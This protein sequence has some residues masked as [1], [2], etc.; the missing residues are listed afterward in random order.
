MLL[1]LLADLM[2][3]GRIQLEYEFAYHYETVAYWYGIPAASL[4]QSDEL[5]YGKNIHAA[6]E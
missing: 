3:F 5:P 2:P 6:R 4:I 1:S